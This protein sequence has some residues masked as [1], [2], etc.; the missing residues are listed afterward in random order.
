[1]RIFFPFGNISSAYPSMLWGTLIL[2][3][4]NH[5]FLRLDM[6]VKMTLN[7]TRPAPQTNVKRCLR[8]YST[9]LLQVLMNLAEAKENLNTE[10]ANPLESKT[11]KEKL[12]KNSNTTSQ[13]NILAESPVL[14]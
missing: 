1:M 8:Y 14:V 9:E 4:K 3:Y 2:P 10:I 12:L 11:K 5:M 6:L 13:L 7:D